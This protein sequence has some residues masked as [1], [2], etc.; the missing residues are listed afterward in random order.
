MTLGEIVKKYRETNCLSQRQFATAC[1]LSN[2]YI[3][4]LEKNLNPKTAQPMVPSLVAIKKIADAMHI[5]LNDLLS[6]ADDMPVGIFDSGDSA[7]NLD[8]YMKKPAAISDDGRV[9]NVMDKI[10]HLPED[11]QALALRMIE[12]LIDNLSD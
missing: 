1:S 2:G 6:Y 8:D 11:R 9:Q 3:S 12:S 5:P 4:M 10:D 7:S